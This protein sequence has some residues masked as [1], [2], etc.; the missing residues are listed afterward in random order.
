MR[1][2]AEM[3]LEVEHDFGEKYGKEALGELLEYKKLDFL[4]IDV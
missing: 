4:S 3:T 1:M 2:G